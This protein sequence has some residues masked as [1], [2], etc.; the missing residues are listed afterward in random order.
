MRGQMNLLI[1]SGFDFQ[2]CDLCYWLAEVAEQILVE[3][4]ESRM[5]GGMQHW[6]VSVSDWWKEFGLWC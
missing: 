1:V 5:T 4:L 3:K 2:E 6:T